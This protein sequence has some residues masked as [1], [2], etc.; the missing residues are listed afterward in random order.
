MLGEG[1]FS[2]WTL[3]AQIGGIVEEWVIRMIVAR[4]LGRRQ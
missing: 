1:D 4:K 2:P 3:I